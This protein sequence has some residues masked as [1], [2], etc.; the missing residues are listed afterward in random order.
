LFGRASEDGV[1]LFDVLLPVPDMQLFGLKHKS[2]AVVGLLSV[3]VKKNLRQPT[4]E[5]EIA[6]VNISPTIDRSSSFQSLLEAFSYDEKNKQIMEVR[7]PLPVHAQWDAE[8]SDFIFPS[9]EKLVDECKKLGCKKGHRSDYYDISRLPGLCEQAKIAF[10]QERVWYF[11]Q[12]RLF[13]PQVVRQGVDREKQAVLPEAAAA[14]MRMVDSTLSHTSGGY[15]GL[16]YDEAYV[17]AFCL[18]HSF[19]DKGRMSGFQG[20]T[21]EEKEKQRK[22]PA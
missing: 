1:K 9:C 4:A 11:S 17:E 3:L 15:I 14:L 6:L 20:Y 13:L 22:G 5:A 18:I 10:P 12:K 8:N 7:F 2:A 19:T 21:L 16:Y